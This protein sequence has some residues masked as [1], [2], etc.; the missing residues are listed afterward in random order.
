[1]PLMATLLRMAPIFPVSDLAV[2]FA[3]YGRLGFGTRAYVDGGYGYV[4]RDGVELH[5]GVVA[6]RTPHGHA[7]AYLWV[8][9]ADETAAEWQAAGVEVLAPRDTA[10]G[11]HEGAVVDLDGN[12][13]RFGSPTARR[14]AG[15]N[16][17]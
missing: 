17:D 14:R 5:L 2:S 11:Q 12:V 15:R 16:G 1:M 13:I 10:W 9:D 7:S 6:D 3:H 4:T 8:D